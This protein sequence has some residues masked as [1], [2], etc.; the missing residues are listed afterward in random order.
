MLV[1]LGDHDIGQ[2]IAECEDL[3]ADASDAV[4]HRH[5]GQAGAVSERTGSNLV[6]LAGI[7]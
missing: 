1:T 2:A 7:V 6:T 4:G 5:A 3:V